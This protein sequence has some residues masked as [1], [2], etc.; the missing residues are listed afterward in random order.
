MDSRSGGKIVNNRRKRYA[1]GPYDHPQQQQQQPSVEEEEEQVQK[2][3]NWLTGH[4][5]PATRTIISGAAK[6]L[7][8]VFNS[9]GSSSS[10]SSESDNVSM[11][12]DDAREENDICSEVDEL[13]KHP[14]LRGERSQTK[15]L[16]EQLIMQET[17]SRKERDRLVTIINSRVVDSSSLEGEGNQTIA[18]DTLDHS[19]RAIIEARKWL[20]EKRD[21]LR[22][23]I[24]LGGLSSVVKNVDD[25]FGSPV[26]MAK[27]YMKVRPPWASPAADHSGLGTPLQMK[28]K[29]FDEETP[30][31]VSGD[32]LSSLKKKNS[33]ASGS[34]NIH[35]E[36][37]KVR[38]KATEDMLRAHPFKETDYQL[39]LVEHK[40]EPKSAVGDL[41]GT[42][43]T[44]KINDSSSLRL[45]KLSDVPIKWSDVEITQ[46]GE[47]SESGPLNP[48][49]PIQLQD[50]AIEAIRVGE[51]AASESYMPSDP[52]VPSEH[53]DGFDI[54]GSDAQEETQQNLAQSSNGYTSLEASLSRGEND[55]YVGGEKLKPG[56]S[57]QDKSTKS[58]QVE[59]KCELLSE[60][61]V[62]VPD[63]N[64]TTGSPDMPSE[65]ISQEEPELVRDLAKNGKVVKQQGK[66]PVQNARKTR[67]KR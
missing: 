19:S 36:I 67:A 1:V 32:S 25:T 29:L 12:E 35:E 62:D 23:D 26:E 45:S 22:S 55:A 18:D 49:S 48:A 21:G 24:S 66:R 44:E 17:F 58:N 39:R 6:I 52:A 59:D 50:Q 64:E 3:P 11:F 56:T 47:E 33:F 8:S 53:N 57:S 41:T 20:E 27:S 51:H 9:E 10:S 16:I 30:Y 38:S 2:S 31:T 14:Q 60:S 37:R 34:W 40:A 65:D 13:N 28:A 7:T 15:H 61:A 46:D 54:T 63:M 42:S 4:V 5:F 43:T